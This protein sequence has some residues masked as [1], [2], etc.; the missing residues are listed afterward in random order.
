MAADNGLVDIAHIIE[1]SRA[2]L[3]AHGL[4]AFEHGYQQGGAVRKLLAEAGFDAIQ[5]VRDYGGNERVTFGFA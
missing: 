5:T 1:H 2:F 3:V 4:L